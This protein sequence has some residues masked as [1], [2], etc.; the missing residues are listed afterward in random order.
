MVY[1]H[2]KCILISIFTSAIRGSISIIS[3][4]TDCATIRLEKHTVFT[5]WKTCVNL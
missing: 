5:S 1:W 4:I 2:S 3:I